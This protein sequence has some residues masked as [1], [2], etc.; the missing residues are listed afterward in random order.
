MV[1]K[2]LFFKLS[3]LL[4]VF[5][6]LAFGSKTF[7]Q[8]ILG[9]NDSWG[10]VDKSGQFVIKPQF[11]SVGFFKNGLA[12]VTVGLNNA[13]WINKQ[14]V[15][16]RTYNPEDEEEAVGLVPF[17]EHG[18]FGYKNSAGKCVIKPQFESAYNF[19]EH[20]AKITFP[21]SNGEKYGFIDETGKLKIPA[22][23]RFAGDFHEGLA[24]VFMGNRSGYINKK[25]QI[26]IDAKY[27]RAKPFSEGLAGVMVK[28]YDT[29]NEPRYGFID[30]NGNLKIK[31]SFLDV[32]IFSEGLAAAQI[33]VGNE[34]KWGFIDKNG[35]WIISPRFS[36][37][38][39]FTEGLAGA[40]I[41]MKTSSK[42]AH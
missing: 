25:G 37:A 16:V 33:N 21:G 19:R 22:V 28:D 15:I 24:T 9:R 13:V 26:V 29:K 27:A 39:D 20:F 34:K 4:A 12:A 18:L 41:D 11:W 40:A 36:R 2:N 17:T 35:S 8:C 31:P 3:F 38:M 30:K 23:Y 42:G 10:F 6:V 14:G 5:I 32:S 1:R 7:S